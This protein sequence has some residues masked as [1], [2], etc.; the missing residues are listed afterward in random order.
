MTRPSTPLPVPDFRTLFE[1]VPGL[2]LVL[3]P[4]L[5]IVAASDAYLRATM[6]TREQ[7]LGRPLFEVF[8]DNPADPS[9]TGVRNLHASLGRVLAQRVPDAMP[10][11]KYDIRRPEG[12]FEERFWSP[13]NSPVL[14]PHGELAYIIHRVEDVTEFVRLKQ[15]GREQH[16]VT[17][18]LRTRAEQMETE[19]YLRARQL[20]DANRQLRGANEE[21]GRLYAKTKEL[22][23]LKTEF[24]ANI[25]HELRTPLALI[26][27]RSERLLASGELAEPCRRD[28]AVVVRNAQTLLGH[29]NDLLDMSKLEAGKMVAGYAEVDVAALVRLVTAHFEGLGRERGIRFAV[30]TPEHVTG[31][32]DPDK[33]QRVVLNLLSNA[34][35]FAPAEGAVRCTLAVDGGRAVIQ[36]ADT[37]PG[38]KREL[39]EAIFE[40]FRQGD[41]GPTRRLGGTG[42]GLSIAKEFVELHGGTITVG[43][44]PEGGA[45]FTAAVPLAAPS[46]AE[47]RRTEAGLDVAPLLRPAGDIAPPGPVTAGASDPDRPLVLVVEDN[48]EM[49]RLVTEILVSEY[50]VASAFDGRDGLAQARALRPDLIVSD[51]MMPGLSGEELARQV[52]ATPDLDDVPIVMLTAKADD[53]LR[54]RVLRAGVQDYVMKPFSADELKARVGNLVAMKRAR[55]VLQLELASQVRDLDALARELAHRKRAL[56]TAC[57]SLRVARD[58]AEHAAKVKSMFLS[59][60][61]HELRTPLTALQTY[62]HLLARDAP[63]SLPPKHQKT[64][65]KMA[66]SSRRLFGLIES[67]LE[68]A[69]IE[70][71]RLNVRI[72][73]IDL[74]ALAESA[75]EEARELAGEKPLAVSLSVVPG[76]PPLMSDRRL[77]RLVLGNLVSNGVKF[78][79]RGSVEVRLEHDG[80]AHRLVVKDSGPGIPPELQTAVFEPFEQ[81]EPMRHKHTPGVGL[82]LALVR[83][84]VD[85][86]GGRIELHSEVGV[87]SIFTVLLPEPEPEAARASL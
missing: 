72:E 14:D 83:E 5:T 58:Q 70:S 42:L 25:S 7:I 18:Q 54:V 6:T 85:A 31:Q 71:G 8:P 9:A 50:R 34:F 37:G 80:H 17:E 23:R 11:Q 43:D 78:A 75:V 38:V 74:A 55:E 86:L 57:H 84:L 82:G 63:A 48:L 20:D 61:S 69:R 44:A 66:G 46:G 67:L 35:K 3:T 16:E 19:I 39:R 12:G 15:A 36:V 87:G 32:V 30:E 26:I 62:L 33:L 49:N 2:Y 53:A 52:R 51:V 22:D 24:F 1:S 47:V 81:L 10:V 40:R 68:Q 56:E 29:V 4:D 45:L 65:A 59:L 76:L 27:G 77:V 41:G 13:V 21:L 60:V 28:L 73:P 64:I 79:E